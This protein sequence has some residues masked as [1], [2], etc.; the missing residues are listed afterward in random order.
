[1]GGRRKVQVKILVSNVVKVH[2]QKNKK[3]KQK[4]KQTEEIGSY[5]KCWHLTLRARKYGY[6]QLYVTF[7]L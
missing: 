3:Q 4:Q 5:I 7:S 6:Y 1:V 2:P